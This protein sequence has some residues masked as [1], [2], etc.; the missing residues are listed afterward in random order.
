MM[1][2]EHCC[3]FSIYV[4]GGK[5]E[6]GIEWE[7]LVFFHKLEEFY[8]KIDHFFIQMFYA[9]DQCKASNCS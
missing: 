7:F 1:V 5:S 4:V 8:Y 2:F 3:S 6:W 9:S